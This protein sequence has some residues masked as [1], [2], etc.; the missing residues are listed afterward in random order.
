MNFKW[1]SAI[2]DEVYAHVI[3]SSKHF[4]TL[5]VTVLKY[6]NRIESVKNQTTVN[7]REKITKLSLYER[8]LLV[9]AVLILGNYGIDKDAPQF[10]F[11]KKSRNAIYWFILNMWTHILHFH[12]VSSWQ[13][14]KSS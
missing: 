6:I 14:P 12:K 5:Q 13:T 10:I 2:K 8:L 7:L 1:A 3:F 4:N 11:A 9:H